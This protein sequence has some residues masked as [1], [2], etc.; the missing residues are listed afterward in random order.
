MILLTCTN[1][2]QT[3]EIDDAF[4]GGVC[5]CSHCGAI[6]TVPSHLK[7][8]S[9][10]AGGAVAPSQVS[11][12]RRTLY[13]RP[14]GT[15][16]SGLEELGEVISGSGLAGSGG[17]SRRARSGKSVSSG[18]RK[19][20]DPAGMRMLALAVAALAVVIAGGIILYVVRSRPAPP[21]VGPTVGHTQVSPPNRTASAEPSV[22]GKAAAGPVQPTPS[23]TDP[24]PS[25]PAG[26][27][28]AGV[29]LGGGSVAYVL[30]RGDS[31]R[32]TLGFVTQLAL[33]SIRSLGPTSKYQVLFW[34]AAGADAGAFD[35]PDQLRLAD[36]ES[37]DRTARALEDVVASG[38]TDAS[39]AFGRA[40]DQSPAVIVLVTAK[41]WQL[42]ADFAARMLALIG[43]RKIRVD[44]FGLIDGES[45][46]LRELAARTGGT[47]TPLDLNRLRE[48]VN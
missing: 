16:A 6:Q 8:A 13:A 28:F 27:V 42:D 9:R 21:T 37:V 24:A 5:R 31:A 10:P 2:R 12:D 34:D 17:V 40:V 15:D 35:S 32:Q 41:G 19:A 23:D 36:E 22:G 38:Q 45:E 4:A 46:G 25:T 44:T 18:R 14:D 39:G 3:L 29:P 7:G 30:D 48:L 43:E 47:F 20:G 11:P 33:D 1:C 26:P